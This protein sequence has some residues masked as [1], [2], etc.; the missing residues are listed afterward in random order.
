MDILHVILPQLLQGLLIELL[1]VLFVEAVLTVAE[2]STLSSLLKA[3]TV[4]LLAL[5][6]LARAKDELLEP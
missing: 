4:V 3:N 1:R 5:G 2:L 6:L